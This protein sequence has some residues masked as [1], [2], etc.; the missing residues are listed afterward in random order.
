MFWLTNLDLHHGLLG[1]HLPKLVG[2]LASRMM[3]RREQAWESWDFFQSLERVLPELT[4][5]RSDALN[6]PECKCQMKRSNAR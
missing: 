5:G 2:T 6:R 3:S 1:T 4:I